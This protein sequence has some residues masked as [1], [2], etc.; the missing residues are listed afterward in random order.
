[1]LTSMNARIRGDLDHIEARVE[2]RFIAFDMDWLL[3]FLGC[4]F[5]GG[6]HRSVI[7]GIVQRW[8]EDAEGDRRAVQPSRRCAHGPK[9]SFIGIWVVW[10]VSCHFKSGASSS[11]A[12]S[13]F[14]KWSR[15]LKG[16][17]A[18]AQQGFLGGKGRMGRMG[19][20]RQDM[21]ILHFGQ[22]RQ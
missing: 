16:F 11:L 22:I 15:C 21:R 14:F 2:W 9:I 4:I 7:L 17:A 18:V 8:H 20:H 13:I 5:D 19:V 6:D 10:S 12:G 3:D 1:M